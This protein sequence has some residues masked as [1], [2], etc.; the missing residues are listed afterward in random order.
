MYLVFQWGLE[1]CSSA[2]RVPDACF[3]SS[4]SFALKMLL[5]FTLQF[6]WF[7]LFCIYLKTFISLLHFISMW[8]H[9]FFKVVHKIFPGAFS[10]KSMK[11]KEKVSK[12]LFTW[13][14]WFS[15]ASPCLELDTSVLLPVKGA[16]SSITH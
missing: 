3:H 1:I 13:L 2:I 15:W 4:F 11:Q 14:I 9:L 7:C 16:C 8:F 6:F 10:R 5:S 12:S